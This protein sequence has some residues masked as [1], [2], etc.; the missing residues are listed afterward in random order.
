M[1]PAMALPVTHGGSVSADSVHPPPSAYNLSPEPMVVGNSGRV[2]RV[3]DGDHSLHGMRSA[4][5][6]TD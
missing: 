6:Y 4:T 5:K 3:P 2:S 1:A